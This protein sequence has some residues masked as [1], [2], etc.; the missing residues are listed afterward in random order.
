MRRR[1]F[2]TLVGG[3]DYPRRVGLR[4][5]EARDGRERSSA[6]GQMQKITAGKFHLNLPSHHS[7]T[8]SPRVSSVAPRRDRVP[9]RS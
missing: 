8:S 7:I 9:S 4:P 2:I 5:S 6:S 1:E 3:H